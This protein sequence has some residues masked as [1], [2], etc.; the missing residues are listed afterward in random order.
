MSQIQDLFRLIYLIEGKKDEDWYIDLI[1]SKAKG[2]SEDD[3]V[4]WMADEIHFKLFQ[5]DRKLYH[6]IRNE[7]KSKYGV[8]DDYSLWRIIN[9][10]NLEIYKK[11]NVRIM[12]QNS[13]VLRK[14]KKE[15]IEIIRK[16]FDFIVRKYPNLKL[17]VTIGSQ[18][19]SLAGQAG[20][21][22]GIPIENPVDLWLVYDSHILK[23]FRELEKRFGSKWVST[24]YDVFHELSHVLGIHDE[25]K[26]DKNALKLA[27]EFFRSLGR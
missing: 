20:F 26:A 11:G 16:L 23:G 7:L 22:M 13:K 17:Q 10:I 2:L 3:F 19:I 8:D 24:A 25:R 27:K 5:E 15:D 21:R 1:I 14:L 18:P 9:N 4:R 12:A 6:K